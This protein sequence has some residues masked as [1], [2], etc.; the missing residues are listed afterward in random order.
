MRFEYL[1]KNPSKHKNSKSTE[2]KATVAKSFRHGGKQ[3]NRLIGV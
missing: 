1:L 2:I 3:Y